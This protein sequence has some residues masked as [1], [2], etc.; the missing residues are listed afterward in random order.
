MNELNEM[1]AQLQ[2]LDT[3]TQRSV[4]GSWA[5]FVNSQCIN[6]AVRILPDMPDEGDGIDGYTPWEGAIRTAQVKM[7]NDEE[8]GGDFT[9]VL[10]AWVA[11]Q[12]HISYMMTETGGD[13]SGVEDTYEFL[14]SRAPTR[15]RFEADFAMRVKMGMR[16]GIT[17]KEFVNAEYARA[18][19][20]HHK[21]VAKG[22]H[23]VQLIDRLTLAT[24]T[25]VERGFDDLPDWVA[26]TLNQ[27][28]V[29]KLKD[30]WTRL[31]MTRTNPRVNTSNRDAAEGDQL[32]I[33]EAL[34]AFDEVPHEPLED[35]DEQES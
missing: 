31:E 26:E 35:D 2:D 12:R 22:E 30:R 28:F 4:I 24:G 11:M 9:N 15:D 16:P 6:Q 1:A 10:P 20:Q 32:L 29:Q 14:T 13:P 25:Q 3:Y 17:R 19:D 5:F 7:T 21:L 23:A 18:M 34:K 27:K 8:E 33:V